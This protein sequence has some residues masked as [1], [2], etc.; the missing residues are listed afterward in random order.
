MKHIFIVHK[1]TPLTYIDSCVMYLS[2]YPLN[3]HS[4]I[5]EEENREKASCQEVKYII[6]GQSVVGWV[7]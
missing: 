7:H 3:F 6:F 4:Y 2:L 5:K 1:Y